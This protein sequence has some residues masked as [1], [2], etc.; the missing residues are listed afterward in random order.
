MTYSCA[1]F[2]GLDADLR[3]TSLPSMGGIGVG[4][5]GLTGSPAQRRPSIGNSF[6]WTTTTGSLSHS[7][8]TL[9]NI[10]LVGLGL[11]DTQLDAAD[12][13]AH[14]SEGRV[15]A[16]QNEDAL[17]EAQ[18]RKLRHIVRKAD[19]RQGHRVDTRPLFLSSIRL[20][21]RDISQVLE[22]GTGWGA[23]GILIATTVPGTTVDTLTLSTQQAALAGERVKAAGLEARVR[24]HLMD[25]RDMPKEWE[26]AFDRLVSVEMVEAVGREFLEV[27]IG[28]YRCSCIREIPSVSPA[29]FYLNCFLVA[30]YSVALLI[31][32]DVMECRRT[33]RRLTGRS[34][35]KLASG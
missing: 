16:M 19:I 21:H 9:A 7:Q 8:S 10:H 25:Y 3:S 33:G 4:S 14:P 27:G 28:I 20:N 18:M 1:I 35:E 2:P 22:I 24:V 26:G 29:T 6:E 15:K 13:S 31:D 32:M 11:K 12:G 5:P 30:R 34:K 23:L 17:Y